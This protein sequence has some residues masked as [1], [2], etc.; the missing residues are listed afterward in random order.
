MEGLISD[1]GKK[2]SSSPGHPSRLWNPSISY[3]VDI[4]GSFP[5]GRGW[6]VR[7][8]TYTHVVPNVTIRGAIP[9]LLHIFYGLHTD[10]FYY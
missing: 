2:F 6:R 4:G 8:F 3:P 9:P 1:R 5:R 7:R 10:N